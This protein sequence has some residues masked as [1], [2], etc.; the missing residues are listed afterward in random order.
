M[1]QAEPQPSTNTHPQPTQSLIAS[2][3]SVEPPQQTL[4]Q[5]LE[6]KVSSPDNSKT[7]SVN[8]LLDSA[9]NQSWVTE[10]LARELNLPQTA[11]TKFTVHGFH[12]RTTVVPSKRVSCT[13]TST[14]SHNE[15]L[16][17]D[18]W[19]TKQITSALPHRA[20]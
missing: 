4:L 19:T 15:K 12:G 17:L 9:S 11:S 1:I 6:V 18:L 10:N 13:L 3:L 7:R 5:V 14:E 16:T 8:L 20:G 2:E